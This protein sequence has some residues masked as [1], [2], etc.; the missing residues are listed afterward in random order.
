MSS[1]LE[2][3]RELAERIRKEMSCGKSTINTMDELRAILAAPV[4]ERQQ[5]VVR[6]FDI[7]AG[8][9][10]GIYTYEDPKGEWVNFE[11]VA[12]LQATAAPELAELQA[13]YEQL[14]ADCWAACGGNGPANREDLL[15]ALRLMNEADDESEAAIAQLTAEIESIKAQLVLTEESN[16]GL[17]STISADVIAYT[18]LRDERDA[19][20]ERLKGGRSD[21]LP[22]DVRLP[23]DT[24]IR[25]GNTVE[26]LMRCIE[27]RKT[28]PDCDRRFNDSTP[29]PVV[30]L[31]DHKKG[32][33]AYADHIEILKNQLQLASQP[34]PVSDNRPVAY[35]R[36]EG[37]PNNLIKCTFACPGAFGVYRQPAP[38]SVALDEGVEFE[39]WWCRTPVLRKGKLQ[40]AQEAWEA[41]A[42][43]D[44]IKELNQ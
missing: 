5:C 33:S 26:S 31:S 20:I 17:S 6:R 13:Q 18:A 8:D 25:L 22:C 32:L 3:T 9:G 30:T 38:V 11:D 21:V 23:P 12:E 40:I 39:K 7:Q 27:L 15:S 1:K 2:I 10:P 35:M 24:T 42:C 43:L 16:A 19:L 29:E 4:V 41:R 37:T 28:R 44:K 14:I 36:N 34:A